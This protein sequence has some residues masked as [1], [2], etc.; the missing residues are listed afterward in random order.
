VAKLVNARDLKSLED[1]TSCQFD[2]GPGHE[3]KTGM[4]E[5][6]E[7]S[8]KIFPESGI[9]GAENIPDS[10]PDKQ[11]KEF[12]VESGG[13]K[14]DFIELQSA[15]PSNVLV[16]H[17]PGFAVDAEQY[18]ESMHGSMEKSFCTIALKSY[19]EA[20]SRESIVEALGRAI[21]VSGKQNV[22]LHGNSFGAAVVY[23]LISD[24]NGREFLRGNNV[25]GAVLET[26]VLDKEHLQ[27]RIRLVPDR[28]LV[29]GALGLDTIRD[30]RS[31]GPAILGLVKLSRSQKKSILLEALR[32]KTA[33][34]EIDVPIHVVFTKNENISDNRKIMETLQS[35]AKEI[36]S[37]TVM[38]ADDMGHHVAD[39]SYGDM[40]R[41]EEKA[42]EGF[43]KTVSA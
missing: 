2:S 16:L 18:A 24:P 43:V 22:I 25:V 10:Q 27:S 14:F 20:Y 19:G 15:E 30:L 4:K 7:H 29:V 26:P 1:N 28:I 12:E 6:F 21:Q 34:R 41:S 5:R 9:P 39:D 32:E 37:N 33:G 40:W 31:F 23:D 17:F 13:Q 11:K 8:K 35:Q 42:I 36:S 38:S 3:N